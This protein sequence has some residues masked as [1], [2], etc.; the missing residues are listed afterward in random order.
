VSVRDG[1]PGRAG[2][3]PLR[4]SGDV[5]ELLQVAHRC[6]LRVQRGLSGFRVD[7]LHSATDG[8]NPNFAHTSGKHKGNNQKHLASSL[9]RQ[10]APCRPETTVQGH[11]AIR[12]A[13][14][15]GC[16]NASTGAGRQKHLAQRSIRKEAKLCWINADQRDTN[17]NQ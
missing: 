10:G 15:Q 6:G 4:S 2:L 1:M 14:M 8:K 16:S 7:E 5:Q 3:L 12:G 11:G 9:L 17:T 13:G